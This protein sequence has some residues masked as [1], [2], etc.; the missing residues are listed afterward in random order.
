MLSTDILILVHSSQNKFLKEIFKLESAD[1][2]LGH[3]TILR[4]K[5][6]SQFFKVGPHGV[7]F[8]CLSALRASGARQ[9]R[10]GKICHLGSGFLILGTERMKIRVTCCYCH[11]ARGEGTGAHECACFCV[12]GSHARAHLLLLLLCF[13]IGLCVC[14]LCTL[15]VDSIHGYV[16]VF[17]CAMC[18]YVVYVDVDVGVCYV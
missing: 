8:Q 13:Y 14:V 4:G 10:V 3:G 18:G 5:A 9:A 12:C 17:C 6:G 16:W 11:M 7:P 2:K 15:C 1:T